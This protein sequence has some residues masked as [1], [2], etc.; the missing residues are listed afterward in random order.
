M[1]RKKLK[2]KPNKDDLKPRL[3][4][5][6]RQNSKELKLKEKLKNKLPFLKNKNVLKP[7]LKP[8]ELSS[9]VRQN[10]KLKRRRNLKPRR[11]QSLKPSRKD[12]K[13]RL[14]LN[15]E[16]KLKKQKLK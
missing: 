12:L 16:Q 13:L 14:N 8:N 7:R 4:P 6:G 9:S 1:G 15:D 5:G 2:L 10:S 3:K 11:R